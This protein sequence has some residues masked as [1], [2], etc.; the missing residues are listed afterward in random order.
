MLE[1]GQIGRHLGEGLGHNRFVAGYE[2]VGVFQ[3]LEFACQVGVCRLPVLSRV[4]V[5]IGGLLETLDCEVL[6][7]GGTL[8]ESCQTVVPGRVQFGVQCDVR[9]SAPPDEAEHAG[10]DNQDAKTDTHFCCEFHLFEHS[11]FP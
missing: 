10:Y 11:R 9:Q 7:E 4:L 6:A 1:R 5:L 8:I 3:R 2:A